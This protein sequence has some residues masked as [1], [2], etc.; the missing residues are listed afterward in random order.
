MQNLITKVFSESDD[1]NDTRIT[2]AYAPNAKYIPF[3]DV[4]ACIDNNYN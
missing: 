2:L 4:W 3:S 1:S